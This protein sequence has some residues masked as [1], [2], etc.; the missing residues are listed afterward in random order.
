MKIY[1]AIKRNWLT[2]KFSENKVPFYREIGMLGHNGLDWATSNGDPVYWDCIDVE[3]LVIDNHIDRNGGLGVK[4]IT[5]DADGLFKHLFWHLQG[6][7]CKPGQI[8]SSGDLIGYADNTGRS[9]GSHLHRGLKRVRKTKL[10]NYINLNPDNGFFG[11][12]DIKPF[13]TN[14]FIKEYVDILKAQVSILRK[15]VY[16]LKKLLKYYET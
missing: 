8:L 3:G 4:I 15:V 1:R 6:F 12:I 2:Q 14:I 5:K 16:L 7:A 11:A 10:G 9:T 13:F